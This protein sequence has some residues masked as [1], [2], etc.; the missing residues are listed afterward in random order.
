MRKLHTH[1]KRITWATAPATLPEPK[2]SQGKLQDR[3]DCYVETCK[4][5]GEQDIKTFDEWLNS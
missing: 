1:I 3:Y 2:Q 4:R 5:L